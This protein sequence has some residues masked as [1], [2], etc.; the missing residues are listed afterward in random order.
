M[1]EH[2]KD[3]RGGNALLTLAAFV[4]VVAGMKAASSLLVPF[5]LAVF[6]AVICAPP[7][8]WLGS[9]GV[10][11]VVAVVVILVV[12][13]GAG[14]LVGTLVGASLNSFLGS[15]PDYQGRLSMRIDP[16]MHWLADQGVSLPS[17]GLKN[18]FNPERVMALAGGLV[19]GLGS[20]LANAV[21]ILLTVVFI[22]LEASGLPAKLRAALRNPERSLAGLEKFSA[23][24]NR[25]V[26]I[27]TA[28][29]ITTGLSITLW[30]VILGVD[31]PVLWGTLAFLL[32]YVPNIGTA[33]AA[34]PAMLLALVQLGPGSA[35]LTVLGFLT[36]G[37][38]LGN[39]VEP[40]LM[41][42]GLGLSTLV[43][44]LSL[45]FWGWVLGPVGMILSVPLTSLVKI[46]LES[47]EET[48]ELAILLGSDVEETKI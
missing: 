11:K 1:D 22:L 43:V 17:G 41:G 3:G 30:L 38:I 24:A 27:K 35:L 34:L 21:L 42:R 44:F 28:I 25:Y 2:P 7:L 6:I 23:S 19:S 31:Y 37:N 14:L 32:N 18:I 29:S 20:V 8:F 47:C 16:V 26:V 9:K 15:L 46:A 36:V 39:L 10:P 4:V 12:A 5:L 33:L 40:K 45:V 48:C 13:L